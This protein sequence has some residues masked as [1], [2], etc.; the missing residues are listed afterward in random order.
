MK[1]P[2]FIANKRDQIVY[3]YTIFDTCL[4]RI[5]KLDSFSTTVLNIPKN[6]IISI[7]RC[8]FIGDFLIPKEIICQF[9]L[10]INHLVI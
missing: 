6:T 2:V 5:A 4:L 7:R 3:I 9:E 8:H 1:N 10:T